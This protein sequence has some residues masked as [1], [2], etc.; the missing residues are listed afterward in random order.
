MRRRE[1]PLAERRT[2][3]LA[4][5]PLWPAFFLVVAIPTAL[6][7]GGT[8]VVRRRTR[9]KQLTE[10]NEVAGFKFAV[11]GV[12]YAVL[13]AFA[14]FVV[15]E[16][17]T[18]AESDVVREA[19]SAVNL[20]RLAGG[21]DDQTERN[22]RTLVTRYLETA[23]ADDWPAMESGAGSAT[24]TRALNALYAG[25]LGYQPADGRQEA[26]LAGALHE[27]SELTEARRERLLKASTVVPGVIWFGLI[28]GG[29]ITI[30][31]TWF[32]GTKNLRAQVLMT[33][34]LS[35]I[36][37][38]GLLIIL[39]VDH[40]FGGAVRVHPD[41]LVKVLEDFVHEAPPAR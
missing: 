30:A 37:C 40:P 2:M 5:L 33:G 18:A 17:L 6:A 4:T 31:F 21:M 22:V 26:I 20:Y 28:T 29:F 23:I 10:N 16:Q 38:S 12:I 25:V 34:G 14:V 9:L 19:G 7:V 13:L 15:W 24:A 27:L 8:I 1:P 32:F 36:V 11:V 3:S 41:V 35:L 39:A